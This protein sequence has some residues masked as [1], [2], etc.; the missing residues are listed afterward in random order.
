MVIVMTRSFL[1]CAAMTGAALLVLASPALAADPPAVQAP[2]NKGVVEIETGSSSGISVRIVED[3]ANIIDDGATRRVLPVVGK[4]TLQNIP[5]LKLLRGIDMAILQQDVLDY[6]RQQK[7]FP[8]LENS[9]SYIAK[10]YNEEFHLLARPE[11]KSMADLTGQKV[12]VDARGGGTAITASRLF[13]LL[14]ISVTV[15]NFDQQTALEKLKKGEIAAMAFVAGKPAP[16]FRALRRDDNLHLVG[17]PLDAKVTAVYVPTRLTTA[18]YPDLVAQDKPVDTVAVGAALYVANLTPDSDRYRNVAAFVDAFFTQFQA[19]LEPGH[20]PK[21]SE[22]NLTAEIPGWRRFPPADQ[23]LK[24]NAPAVASQSSGG[25]RDLKAVFQKFL[26]ERLTVSGAQG[27]TQ[28]QKDQLFGQFQNWL[29][30][31]T[32]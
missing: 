32:R 3:I 30:S 17:V 23:W 20:H 18:D 4:G 22:V 1:G 15:T 28:E 2:N 19:L 31:Q 13:D 16:I 12:N 10:L 26:E 7:L 27:M 25:P 29:T 9:V 5:D 6:A 8:G 24:R 14:K 21:W 11:I